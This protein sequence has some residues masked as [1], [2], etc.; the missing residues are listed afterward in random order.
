MT[1]GPQFYQFGHTSMF[2][3][4][5]LPLNTVYS[6]EQDSSLH[7]NNTCV[8]TPEIK[9]NHMAQWYKAKP[10]SYSSHKRVTQE[11]DEQAILRSKAPTMHISPLTSWKKKEAEREKCESKRA[12]VEVYLPK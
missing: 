1:N 8:S 11:R 10:F 4:N 7:T 5:G 12:H 3:C 2:N 9:T 6:Y